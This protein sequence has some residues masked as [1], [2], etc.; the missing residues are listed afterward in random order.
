MSARTLVFAVWLVIDGVDCCVGWQ[1]VSGRRL[2]RTSV[3]SGASAAEGRGDQRL[4]MRCN[5]VLFTDRSSVAGN[6]LASVRL[7]IRLSVRLSPLYL[8]NRLI[9]DL[10]LLHVI[11]S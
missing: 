8:K 1:S 4:Y 2:R 3:T 11:T 7:S 10:E 5:V 6:A 9:V